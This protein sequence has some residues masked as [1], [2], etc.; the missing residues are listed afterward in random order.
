MVLDE[1]LHI[2][3]DRAMLHLVYFL[4]PTKKALQNQKEFKS[5][6]K[7]RQEWFYKDI[8]VAKNPSWQIV[9]V[10]EPVHALRHTISFDDEAAWGEYRRILHVRSSDPE[11]QA[12]RCEQE[13]WWEIVD[14]RLL[15]DYSLDPSDMDI[16]D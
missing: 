1:G 8:D 10:G 15:N 6:L 16:C 12:R 5:W 9:T 13:D 4:K 7:D 2:G 14:S 3:D 11:W